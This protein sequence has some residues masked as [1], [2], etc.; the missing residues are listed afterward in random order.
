MMMCKLKYLIVACL[1]AFYVSCGSRSARAQNVEGFEEQIA[2]SDSMLLYFQQEQFDKIVRHFDDNLKQQLNKEQLATVWVQLNA[3]LGKY[4]KGELYSAEKIKA[5]GDKVVYQCYFG[6]QKL[7]FL[8][9][10]GKDNKIAGIFF[11]PQPN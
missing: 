6:S 1:T 4:T 2:L 5:V 11:K 7:Y 8:L 3:Q 9:F 10:Y